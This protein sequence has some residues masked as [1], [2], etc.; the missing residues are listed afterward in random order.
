MCVQD[1]AYEGVE[2]TE[3]GAQLYIKVRALTSIA[4]QDTIVYK[5]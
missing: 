4:I 5:R 3:Y 1:Y 2:V